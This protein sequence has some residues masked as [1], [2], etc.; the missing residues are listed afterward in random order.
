VQTIGTHRLLRKSI[1]SPTEV[2]QRLI[3]H[4]NQPWDKTSMSYQVRGPTR[5]TT[6]EVETIN[7]F[8][9]RYPADRAFMNT[10]IALDEDPPMPLPVSDASDEEIVA[11][12]GPS[13]ARPQLRLASGLACHVQIPRSAPPSASGM[14]AY[15]A[16]DA[17]PKSATVTPRGS[18][19][20]LPPSLVSRMQAA[21]QLSLLE[22]YAR[23]YNQTAEGLYAP[24][25]EAVLVFAITGI[26]DDARRA[27]ADKEA[28]RDELEDASNRISD[29]RTRLQR[30]ELTAAAL[31]DCLQRSHDTPPVDRKHSLY[32]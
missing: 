26:R 24:I 3:D 9:R 20:E 23:A 10:T 32:E 5:D 19:A 22:Y 1:F 12:G 25:T 13:N 29:L 8:V 18:S 27:R 21:G 4:D 11:S 31:L 6:A 7:S 17:D 14:S 28:V 15:D 16:I 30:S 2:L